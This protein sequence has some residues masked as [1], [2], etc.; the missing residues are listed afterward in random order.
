[1]EPIGCPDCKR[2]FEAARDATQSHIRAQG[3]WQ[4]ASLRRDDAGKVA[5]LR[6]AQDSAAFLREQAVTAY[7]EHTLTHGAE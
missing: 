6:T 3:H 5:E 2:L 4:V 7:R 1:M